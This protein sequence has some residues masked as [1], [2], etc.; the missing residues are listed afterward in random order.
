MLLYLAGALCLMAVLMGRLSQTCSNL[1]FPS[2]LF[3]LGTLSFI[4]WLLTKL[5]DGFCGK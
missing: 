4:A 1:G 2:R 5:A 3:D